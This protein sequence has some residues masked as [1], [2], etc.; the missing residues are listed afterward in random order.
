MKKFNWGTGIALFYS[1]F[2]IIMVGLVIKSTYSPV[3]MVKNNYYDDDIN[4][5]A[6][7]DKKQNTAKMTQEMTIMYV[8]DANT[9]ILQFPHN[10][11][12]PTGKVTFFRPSQNDK[13]RI[14]EL[15]TDPA[16]QMFIRL[17]DFEKGLW[18]VQVEWQAEDKIYY[19]EEKINI[20]PTNWARPVHK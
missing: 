9:V 11:P 1:L 16:K 2:A 5:Q 18:R 17:D 12:A 3:L 13:D 19:K 20:E 8:A 14:F 4:L 15:K 10:Q 7:L 6:H